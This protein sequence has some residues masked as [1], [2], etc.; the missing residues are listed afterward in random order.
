MMNTLTTL[1][2]T[3]LLATSTF[4]ATNA[5]ATEFTAADN[6]IG[7]QLCM[8]VAKDDKL[9]L[10]QTM[11]DVRIKKHSLVNKLTCNDL[12]VAKFAATYDLENSAKFLNLDLNTVTTIRDLAAKRD[13][14]VLVVAGSR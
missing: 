1:G 12:S 11:K 13:Q 10:S 9:A 5:N 2:V 4:V 3:L 7:T 8:A 14:K 6:S